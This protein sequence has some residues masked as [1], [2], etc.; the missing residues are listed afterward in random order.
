MKVVTRIVLRWQN[1]HF[2][3]A[4]EDAHDYDGPV[5]RADTTQ[6]VVPTGPWTPQIP[7]LQN[8]FQN[9]QNLYNQGTPQ[10]YPGQTVATSPTLA[11]NQNDI[12]SFL[13][14]IQPMAQNA[15]N[16]AFNTAT[17]GNPVQNAA[18]PLTGGLQQGILQ[19][20]SG[21]NGSL[22]FANSML[23]TASGALNRAATTPY[24]GLNTAGAPTN[25][26][27][28][29]DLT[30][31]LNQSLQGGALNPYLDQIIGAA[32]R[33]MNRQFEQ[34][35]IPGVRDAAMAA[36]Q[37]GGSAE[38]IAR[39]MAA[40][41]LQD[42]VGDI[43]A[44]LY[45]QAFDTG[46]AERSNAMGLVANAAGQNQQAQLQTGALNQQGSQAQQTLGLNAAD[47]ILQQLL[48][49]TQG[50]AQQ[51]S[52]GTAQ[53]GDLLSTGSAQNLQQIF[54]GLGLVPQLQSANLAQLGVGNQIGLQQ[55]GQA[56]AGIDSDI[57]K[58]FFNQF[59]P[60]ANLAQ[61]QNFISGGYGGSVGG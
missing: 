11:Q 31:Q 43:V 8:L 7:Y 12:L 41:N 30:S 59:A 28:N 38:G 55:L 6:Q 47:M 56:Q 2:V 50:Q 53:A 61:F 13:S 45:G 27:G 23:P 35:T 14:S 32:T 15:M 1:G 48:G 57:A 24:T 58:F 60:Y 26:A 39:G 4:T 44:R 18:T 51:I 20:L 22:N 34:Q 49:G 37:R 42:N 46:A 36:G 3:P 29:I 19:L 9:A 54:Q 5:V 21:N 40:Q 52:T 33:S 17:A 16:T 10:Y 25:A